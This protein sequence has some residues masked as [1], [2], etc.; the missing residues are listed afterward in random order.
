MIKRIECLYR[1]EQNTYS[2]ED[3]KKRKVLT[4]E[5]LKEL[6]KREGKK[7]DEWGK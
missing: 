7:R 4:D 6:I 2:K 1:K 5:E 3:F